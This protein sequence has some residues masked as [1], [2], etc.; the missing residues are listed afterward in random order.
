MEVDY[1]NLTEPIDLLQSNIDTQDN[2]S[3]Q[4][5]SSYMGNMGNT[6]KRSNSRNTRKK[7][8]IKNRGKGSTLGVLVA[9]TYKLPKSEIEEI[10]RIAYW[11]R[12]KIQ[13]IVA[14]ALARYASSIDEE[15]KRPLPK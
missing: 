13:D 4:S 7:G 10:E 6:N 1:K 14:E 12:R 3:T 5:N 9:K 15:D 11:Q 2:T 8:T